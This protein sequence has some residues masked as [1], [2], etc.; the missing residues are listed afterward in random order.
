M[1]IKDVRKS[2]IDRKGFGGDTPSVEEEF[3]NGVEASD[4]EPL[5]V[6]LSFTQK[7]LNVIKSIINF[8]LI[9][10]KWIGKLFSKKDNG[11]ST[12]SNE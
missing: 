9:P 8:I 6:K 4:P 2:L 12:V 7:V 5:E 10:F 3:Y 11:I 1:E